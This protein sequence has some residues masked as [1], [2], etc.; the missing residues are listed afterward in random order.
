MKISLRKFLLENL[1]RKDFQSEIFSVKFSLRKI[2][3]AENLKKKISECCYCFIFSFSLKFPILFSILHWHPILNFIQRQF[4][5]SDFCFQNFKPNLFPFIR[6]RFS[7]Y[8]F[9]RN[10]LSKT[11]RNFKKKKG[12]LF[13]A[14][15]FRK[16]FPLLFRFQ[17]PLQ[18]NHFL[19]T[20]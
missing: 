11:N 7:T 2:L 13:G 17:F 18:S 1:L 8:Q 10:F 6:S 20:S 15:I 4:Q 3:F 14:Q 5:F 9:F 16:A 12:H 19:H